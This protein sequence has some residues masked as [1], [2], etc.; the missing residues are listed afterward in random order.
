MI[1]L[2]QR[3]VRDILLVKQ[4]PGLICWTKD[5]YNRLYV[6]FIQ[7]QIWKLHKFILMWKTFGVVCEV[8]IGSLMNIKK[9]C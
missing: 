1:D 4:L 7:P 2:N 8:L 5:S 6:V 9:L 3:K